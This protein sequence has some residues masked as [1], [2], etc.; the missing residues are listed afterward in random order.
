MIGS[1]MLKGK[2]LTKNIG[3]LLGEHG[4]IYKPYD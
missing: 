2:E 1:L 4:S 3:K